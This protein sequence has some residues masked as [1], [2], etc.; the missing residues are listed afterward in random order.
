MSQILTATYRDGNLILSEKLDPS[1]E[2]QTVELTLVEPIDQRTRIEVWE[3]QKAFIQSLNRRTTSGRDWK[4]ED[5]YDR[6][7]H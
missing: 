2:G 1:L 5:L 4:R 3:K 7:Q 6:H